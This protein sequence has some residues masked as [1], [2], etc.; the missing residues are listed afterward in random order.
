MEL[1]HIKLRTGEDLVGPAEFIKD[2]LGYRALK[3]TTP[4]SIHMDPSLGFYAKSWL[5]LSKDNDVILNLEDVMFCK[6]ASDTAEEYYTEFVHK[7]AT[8]SDIDDQANELEELFQT[9]LESKSSIKH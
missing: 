1:K 3:V 5:L 4:V 6:P 8:E 7:Y 9:L 2:N